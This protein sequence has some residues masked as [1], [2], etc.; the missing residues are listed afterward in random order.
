V[1]RFCGYRT[2]EVAGSSRLAPLHSPRE[3][4]PAPSSPFARRLRSCSDDYRAWKRLH[5]RADSFPNGESLD[6]ARARYG[7]AYERL[8]TR[9]ESA[10]LVVAHEIPVRYA[11]NAAEGSS[12]PDA[13]HRRIANATLYLFDEERLAGAARHLIGAASPPRS[14]RP[15]E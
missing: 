13:P 1:T 7:R 15:A 4:V 14:P 11:L 9:R 5:T 10:V 8:L 2:Q 3:A 6:A 12:D